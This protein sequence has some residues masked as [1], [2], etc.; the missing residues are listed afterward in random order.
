MVVDQRR[1][2]SAAEFTDLL[3]LCQFLP[4]PNIINMAVAI[5]ARCR[6]P[7]GS[8][9]AVVGLLAAPMVI[10]VALGG[11]YTRYQHVPM[12]GHAFAGLAAAATG[13]VIAMTLRIA[14]PQRRHKAGIAIAVITFA[15]VAILRIPLLPAM[16]VMAPISVLLCRRFP[17]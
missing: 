7:F 10:V 8:V 4:G 1:W 2:L 5:G 9:A 15:A 14:A 6:G 3:A 17:A 16:L 12:V 11:I 13:L